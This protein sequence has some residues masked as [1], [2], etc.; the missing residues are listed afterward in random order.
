MCFCE[1]L[2]KPPKLCL[3]TPQLTVRRDPVRLSNKH[4]DY[5]LTARLKADS[6]GYTLHDSSVPEKSTDRSCRGLFWPEGM[7]QLNLLH[8]AYN[9]KAK[10]TTSKG[11]Q[12]GLFF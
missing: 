7:E 6:T 9:P 10:I 5:Q 4:L 11:Q 8:E 1:L 12:W 2:R 3:A